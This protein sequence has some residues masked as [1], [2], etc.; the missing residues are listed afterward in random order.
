MRVIK[1][2]G[3]RLDDGGWLYGGIIFIDGGKPHIFCNHGAVEVDTATVGQYTG[4]KDRNGQT[5]CEGDIV[6]WKN[7]MG[8]K[9]RSVIGFD[10]RSFVFADED[11]YRTGHFEGGLWAYDCH[12][13]GTIHDNPE[14]LKT[15]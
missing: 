14:L 5:L 2:R 4:L 6:E 8:I 12:I 7:L 13:I 11:E 3:K 15:E 10:G 1:F 9:V